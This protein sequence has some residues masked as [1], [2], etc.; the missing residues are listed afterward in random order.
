[1]RDAKVVSV[2]L[3]MNGLSI[4]VKIPATC[5]LFQL[6]RYMMRRA[7]D[8]GLF[9]PG[10]SV[11]LSYVM[12]GKEFPLRTD[13]DIETAFS[14]TNPAIHVGLVRNAADLFHIADKHW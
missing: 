13:S 10:M 4:P 2:T 11:S 5:N 1:M 14:E 6:N 3:Q 9:S 8:L 7:S 12:R